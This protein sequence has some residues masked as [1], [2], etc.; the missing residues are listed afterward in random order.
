MGD[1]ESAERQGLQ[2]ANGVSRLDNDSVKF[3]VLH[4]REA[5]IAERDE[6]RRAVESHREDRRASEAEWVHYRLQ[7]GIR[8]E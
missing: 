7:T 6:L 1:G 4:I 2:G 5:V 8:D 3:E